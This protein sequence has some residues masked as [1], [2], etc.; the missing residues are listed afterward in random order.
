MKTAIFPSERHPTVRIFVTAWPNDTVALE[1]IK[2]PGCD[3]NKLI[4]R[5]NLNPM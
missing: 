5:D 4:E 1:H 2:H 3:T